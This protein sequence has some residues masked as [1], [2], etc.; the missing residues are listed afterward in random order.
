M[1]A[2]GDVFEIFKED[3]IFQVV[4]PEMIDPECINPNI[5]P[6]R[7]LLH[8]DIGAANCIVARIYLQA[9]ELSEM[10]FVSKKIDTKQLLTILRECRDTLIDA[11]KITGSLCCEIMEQTDKYLSQNEPS[12]API[13]PHIEN[14][15]NKVSNFTVSIKR[16][17]QTF[18]TL[19]NL[20]FKT[21]FQGHRFDK[22]HLYINEELGCEHPLAQLLERN[23]GTLAN[24]INMRNAVEHPKKNN[25]LVITN[26]EMQANGV[27][28][29]PTWH[30]YPHGEMGSI[31]FDMPQ[32]LELVIAFI[33]AA[34]T[35]LL[36]TQASG[37]FEYGI[38]IVE[39]ENLDLSC[40]IRIKATPIIPDNWL[41]SKR[42]IKG[43][44]S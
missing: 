6:Y 18:G 40:P 23:G 7:K 37:D 28:A 13:I 14:L 4:T 25:K 30:H 2:S 36:L 41:K 5:R 38:S 1:L 26:Y 19:F 44:P 22:I 39:E 16:C 17:L 43:T 21:S 34:T 24:I 3:C 29:Q 31:S 10:L 15:V 33:E 8:S 11:Y 27:L 35:H 32:V 9:N 12:Q 42:G 20:I